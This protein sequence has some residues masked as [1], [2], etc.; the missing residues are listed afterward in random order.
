MLATVSAPVWVPFLWARERKQREN[1]YAK[2]R[3][4][5]N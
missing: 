1:R 3:G 5:I 4:E 2:L